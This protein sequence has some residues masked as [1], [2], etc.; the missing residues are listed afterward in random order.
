MFAEHTLGSCTAESVKHTL[1]GRECS[2]NVPAAVDECQWVLNDQTGKMQL[3]CELDMPFVESPTVAGTNVAAPRQW[4]LN[5]QNGDFEPASVTDES[6]FEPAS[7][8]D[9]SDVEPA[10]IPAPTPE[11]IQNAHENESGDDSD[12]SIVIPVQVCFMSH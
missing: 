7:V 1:G 6:D 8:T 3:V 5:A 4:I 12:M 2:I 10:S 11:I 9:E